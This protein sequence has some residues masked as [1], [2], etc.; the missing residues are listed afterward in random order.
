MTDYFTLVSGSDPFQ[1]EQKLYNR[2]RR[3]HESAI[4]YIHDVLKLCARVNKQMEE[5]TRIKH[6]S[7]GLDAPAKAHM[8]VKDPQNPEE[9]L[10]ALIKFDQWQ[11]E[12]K[13]LQ[14]KSP[15]ITQPKAT[16]T[17]QFHQSS[18]EPINGTKPLQATSSSHRNQFDRPVRHSGRTTNPGCWTCGSLEHYQYECPKNY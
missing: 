3:P 13:I 1:L 15:M 8:D 5:S 18:M 10:E 6:L 17:S 4:D 12:S 9:F 14:R 2:M 7:K 16:T 11:L